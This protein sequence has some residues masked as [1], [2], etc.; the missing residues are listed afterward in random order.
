MRGGLFSLLAS[1][2][3]S[4]LEADHSLFLGD[5][6]WEGQQRKAAKPRGGP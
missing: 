5:R 3:H 1:A 6:L 4:G 2:P